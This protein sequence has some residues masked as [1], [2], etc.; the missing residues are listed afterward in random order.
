MG[1]RGKLDGCVCKLFGDGQ[2]YRFRSTS[3]TLRT[4]LEPGRLRGFGAG[5]DMVNPSR[6]QDDF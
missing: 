5:F 4:H 1:G 3:L 2:L 6:N